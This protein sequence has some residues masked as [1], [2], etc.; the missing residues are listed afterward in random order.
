M[1]FLVSAPLKLSQAGVP[2]GSVYKRYIY[3]ILLFHWINAY[4]K[5]TKRIG[6]LSKSSHH[7]VDTREQLKL[8]DAAQQTAQLWCSLLTDFV[9]HVVAKTLPT[10]PSPMPLT[11]VPKCK[12][13]AARARRW[14]IC[15]MRLTL[16]RPPKSTL[17]KLGVTRSPKCETVRRKVKPKMLWHLPPLH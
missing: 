17:P 10:I 12:G 3:M 7:P 16:N 13:T 11:K 1:L 15:K 4:C 2:W 9:L 6:T 8:Q 14:S 5:T